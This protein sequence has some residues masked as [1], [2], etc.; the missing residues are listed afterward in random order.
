MNV[1]SSYWPLHKDVWWEEHGKLTYNQ[2]IAVLTNP[3]NA[4]GKKLAERVH[5]LVSEE[6]G[7]NKKKK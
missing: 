6:L 3:H 5:V 4:L 7:L 1:P 2:R